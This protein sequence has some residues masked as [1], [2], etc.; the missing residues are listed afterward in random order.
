[1]K[2]LKKYCEHCGKEID[3]IIKE[4]SES[5]PVKGM[6]VTVNAKVCFCNECG[7]DLWDDVLD[8][9]NLKKAYRKYR[10]QKNL[11]QPEEI[12]AIRMQYGLSQTSFAKILGFGEKTITRYENGSLQDTAQNNLLVLVKNP[13]DFNIL[14]ER[15]KHLLPQFERK[16]C[17]IRFQRK[18]KEKQSIFV[19]PIKHSKSSWEVSESF[20]DNITSKFPLQSIGGN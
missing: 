4:I 11:L 13:A 7:T 10:E 16:K 5:Y 2:N 18:F 19:F 1:M 6:N 17:E 14:W 12:K 3:V 15:N 9:E 8:D 20:G